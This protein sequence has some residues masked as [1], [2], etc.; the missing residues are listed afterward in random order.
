M[1]RDVDTDID[2]YKWKSQV[3]SKIIEYT[4]RGAQSFKLKSANDLNIDKFTAIECKV[5]EVKVEKIRVLSK[6]YKPEKNHQKRLRSRDPWT[7]Y[8]NQ[9]KK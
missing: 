6:V 8:N 4:S 9:V 5:G 2:R 3:S 7:R 1:D